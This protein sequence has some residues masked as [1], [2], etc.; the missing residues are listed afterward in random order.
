MT[1]VRIMT[2]FQKAAAST[3]AAPL[4][5]LMVGL[6]A[7]TL[8]TL[9][10][11]RI[12]EE[13]YR[14]S[15]KHLTLQAEDTIQSRLTT[16][17]AMLRA[18]AGLIASQQKTVERE[19]F[20]LFV[21]HLQTADQYPGIQGIGFSARLPGQRDAAL[22][23]VAERYLLT[24]FSIYP[25]GNREELHSIIHLEPMDRRNRAAIGYDMFSDSIRR[26]A[27]IRARDSGLPAA[28]GRVQLVQEMDEAVAQAGFLIYMPVYRSGGVPETLEERRRTLLGF[29]YSPFRAND[30]MRGIFGFTSRP[31]IDFEIYDGEIDAGN[32]LYRSFEADPDAE[33]YADTRPVEVA[34]QT[35]T[36]RYWSRPDFKMPAQS[37]F[38]SL[39]MFGGVLAT[40]VLTLLSWSQARARRR[41]D[42]AAAAQR[43][44]ARKLEVLHETAGRLSAQLD[45]E[46]LAQQIT[47]TGRE[48]TGAEI[49]AFFYNVSDEH[50]AYDGHFALSGAPR[51]AFASI[52]SPRKTALFR[53]TF[54]GQGVVRAADITS[55]PRF[56]QNAPYQGFPPGHW[57]VRSYLAVP[58]ISRTGEVIGG[59]LFGHSQ[60]GMFDEQA[61]HSV[62]ALAGHAGIAVDNARLFKA[63]QDEIAARKRIE[64]HQKL[65]LDELNHRVK[66]TLATVQSIAAQTL[67][68]SPDL[69][70]F[71][72]AFEARLIALS[73]A[74]NLLSLSN[75]RGVEL[76][77]L[78]RRELIPHGVDDPNRIAVA[79]ERVMLPPA[80][81]VA[82]GMALHELATNAARHG[83]LS[84]TAGRVEVSWSVSPDSDASLLRLQW[85]EHGGPPVQQPKRRGFGSRMIE[86]GLKHD[87]RGEAKLHFD[88]TGVR[89]VIEAV[90]P[91][92]L[93]AA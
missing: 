32:L 43:R 49:G 6:V 52:G 7:S 19:E 9:H 10:V 12:V 82:I 46:R 41:A 87:L 53:P 64:E 91:A 60:I 5:V 14:E 48:L 15:L 59:L 68:S 34:G 79:G 13:K 56:G 30:L 20:R 2:R 3:L 11:Q 76:G 21:D 61:E 88:S 67:R 16:Y 27:M 17:V 69:R 90:L 40:L 63:S 65:L 86:Q 26:A 70:G 45:S 37:E 22:R 47:D 28:S 66:N 62:V 71:R 58:V 80:V 84:S 77:E 54:E 4:A 78:V 57:P 24:D 42:Q 25:P 51:E 31:P 92:Q 85:Q 75:W 39:I 35:W 83:A 29:V 18:G 1:P 89:C 36:I 50:G 8:A 38:V 23:E 44:N 55:D 33:R 81:A 74:H 72:Q 73:Q 93:A